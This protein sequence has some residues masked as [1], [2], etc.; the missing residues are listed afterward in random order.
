MFDEERW[1]ALGCRFL[2]VVAGLQSGKSSVG[3]WWLAGKMELLGPGNYLVAAPSFPLLNK[4]PIPSCNQHL[5]GILKLGEVVT[6]RSEVQFRVSEQGHVRLW[7]DQ[8]RWPAYDRLNPSRIIFGHAENP[9]SLASATCKAAWLDEPAQNR[10]KQ[11]SFKE[12]RGRLA[13][14]GGPIL[15]TSRPYAFNWFKTDI[16]D[17]A[18]RNRETRSKNKN[19]PPD[20]HLPLMPADSGFEVVNF[21]SID[22]PRFSRA[23]WDNAKL[24]MPGWSFDMRYRGIFSRPAGAIYDCF[25]AERHVL[26]GKDF[27]VDELIELGW[28]IHC[29]I[30][31]GAPN[32]AGIFLY[33]NMEE[34]EGVYAPGQKRKYRRLPIPAYTAFAEYRP[35]EAKRIADHVASMRSIARKNPNMCVGG[36]KSEGQWRS[37]LAS[38]GW[39]CHPPDQPDVEVG[40]GRVYA[41]LANDQL[42]VM[43]TCPKLIEELGRYS[44]PVDEDGNPMEGIE[45]QH[46]YHGLDGLRYI[47]GRL[48]APSS[49]AGVWVL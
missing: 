31:F 23:E 41:A 44:R 18:M 37:E 2:A 42:F 36:A 32:F 29:G 33:E 7:P 49:G 39:P 35:E 8:N 45:D 48:F 25:D 9:D 13:A 40:I 26:P 20:A 34:V 30:D 6:V 47:V 27:K 22:N 16:Y 4:Y 1:A 38:S 43:D 3:D 11:E 15:F 46:E 10:F 19:L 24:T 17:R 12:I 14:T 5:G 21:E 28:P